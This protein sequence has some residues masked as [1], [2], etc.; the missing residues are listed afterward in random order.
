VKA[1]KTANGSKSISN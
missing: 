1:Q